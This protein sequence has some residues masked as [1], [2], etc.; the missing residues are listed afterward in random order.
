[1]CLTPVL[2]GVLF[3]QMLVNRW[4][5]GEAGGLCQNAPNVVGTLRSRRN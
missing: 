2:L 4:L 5:T 1:M 3:D